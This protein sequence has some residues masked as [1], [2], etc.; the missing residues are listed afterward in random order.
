MNSSFG[1][2]N[3]HREQKRVFLVTNC[4][5]MTCSKLRRI[6]VRNKSYIH[7]LEIILNVYSLLNEVSGRKKESEL[8]TKT[9]SS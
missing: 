9:R 4:K 6:Y 7:L 2:Y 3:T 8:Y 5:L 1:G